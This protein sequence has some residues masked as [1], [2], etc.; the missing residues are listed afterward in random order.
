[1]ADQVRLD[2]RNRIHGHGDHD[3][4]RRAADIDLGGEAAEELRV[5][6]DLRQHTDEGDVE[7][8]NDR[9]T[10]Q[11]IVEV[12]GG[13][14]ASLGMPAFDDLLDA[15]RVKLIQQYVLWRAHESVREATSKPSGTR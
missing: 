7:R 11:H 2:L 1:M 3:Q 12:L 4:D 13:A 15:K 10:R 14:R 9:E 5:A 8:A 6:E